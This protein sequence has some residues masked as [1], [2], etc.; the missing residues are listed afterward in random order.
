MWLVQTVYVLAEVVTAARV[1]APYSFRDDT[2]S[3]S[4]PAP[5]K[6]SPSPLVPF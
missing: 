2:I 6:W 5:A 3:D 1:R 4:V